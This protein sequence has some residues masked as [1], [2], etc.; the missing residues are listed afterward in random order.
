MSV[1]QC[2]LGNRGF[3]ITVDSFWSSLSAN[4]LRDEP[5]DIKLQFQPKIRASFDKDTK[6]FFL[7]GSHSFF[8]GGSQY[9]L[10]AIRISEKVNHVFDYSNIIAELH[11]WGRPYPNSKT[12]AD[13]AV[14]IIPIYTS[15]S[16]NSAGKEFLNL[17]NPNTD[18]NLSNLIPAGHFLRYETCTEVEYDPRWT[19]KKEIYNFKISVGY[20]F[21]AIETTRA[22]INTISG[23]FGIPLDTLNYMTPYS[24]VTEVGANA[25]RTLS[26][27]RKIGSIGV[28]YSSKILAS[29]QEF[30]TRFNRTYY[31]PPDPKKQEGPQDY[32][33]IAI[34]RQKD[35]V[36]G[37]IIVDPKTGKRL[38]QSLEEDDEE[39]KAMDAVPEPTI[40][41]QDIEY[42]MTII[43]GTIGG[44]VLLALVL[45][46]LR[47]AITKPTE[48][49]IAAA[50][51]AAAA[52]AQAPT[53]QWMDL[54]IPAFLGIVFLCIG[55]IVGVSIIMSYRS[56]PTRLP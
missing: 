46:G 34:D 56:T 4:T 38:K 53:I 25:E 47:K 55:T 40:K 6:N 3:P 24:T 39:E 43:L 27:P 41:G 45:W 13:L 26:L 49:E 14:L 19:N 12:N 17:L 10:Y 31:K 7:P 16:N 44:T 36:N 5:C 18:T 48:G 8:I 15:S 21:N 42:W 50:V 32:K 28:P 33:C 20:A 35:I 9:S 29:S 1:G 30:K 51:A 11:F 54:V 22:N 23:P 2:L 37:R 52:M